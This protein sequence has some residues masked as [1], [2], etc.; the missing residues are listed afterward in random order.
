MAD[1]EKTIQ[2][3]FHGADQVGKTIRGVFLKYG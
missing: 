3:I 2:I 1:L